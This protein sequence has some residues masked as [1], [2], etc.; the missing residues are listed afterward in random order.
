MAKAAE[1]LSFISSISDV[2]KIKK[3]KIALL[4]QCTRSLRAKRLYQENRFC[5][6]FFFACVCVCGGGGGGGIRP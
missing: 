1:K 6:W 5:F 4:L 2:S 3:L